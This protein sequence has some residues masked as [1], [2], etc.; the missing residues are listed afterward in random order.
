[1]NDP[2]F[3]KSLEQSLSAPPHIRGVSCCV[4]NCLHNDESGYCTAPSISI[5]PGY[6]S[7]CTD[8]VC[9]SFKKKA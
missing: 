9:A 3:D 5:G 2:L 6:A 7:S 4:K 8:T 1:M